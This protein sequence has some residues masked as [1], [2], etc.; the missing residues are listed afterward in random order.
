MSLDLSS[1]N[2]KNR[3]TLIQKGLPNKFRGEVHN[4]QAF[5][6]S[7]ANFARNLSWTAENDGEFGVLDFVDPDSGEKIVLHVDPSKVTPEMIT[8]AHQAHVQAV[9]DAEAAVVAAEN[10]DPPDEDEIK[11]TKLGRGRFWVI[12]AECV[13][14]RGEWVGTET[15]TGFGYRKEE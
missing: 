3:L 1:P 13:N 15:M 14:Q 2:A 5:L 4:F 10:A 6:Y 9:N 8:A 11:T 7:F 12:D